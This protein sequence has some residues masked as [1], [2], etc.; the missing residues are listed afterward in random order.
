MNPSRRIRA[1]IAFLAVMGVL[2]AQIA[3]A[4]YACP[5]AQEMALA[6][7][8]MEA[9]AEM[10]PCGEGMAEPQPTLCSAHCQQGDQSLDKPAAPA[11]PAIAW[12]AIPPGAAAPDV[13]LAASLPGEQ[14]SLL[15]RATAPS[16]ALRNCSLRI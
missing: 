9:G 3:V 7:V 12:V 13:A 8:G 16:V 2:F 4:A 15:A 14:R 6:A 1:L 11:V 10:P 5:G